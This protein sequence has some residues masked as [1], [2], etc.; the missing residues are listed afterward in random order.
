MKQCSKKEHTMKSRTPKQNVIVAPRTSALIK[1]ALDRLDMNPRELSLKMGNAY[2]HIRLLAKGEKFGSPLM[3][4]EIARILGIDEKALM[5]AYRE[6]KADKAGYKITT[7]DPQLT[8]L[9]SIFNRLPDTT[10]SQLVTYAQFVEKNNPDTGMA[11]GAS[12]QQ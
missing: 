4:R 8:V 10:K 6:D 3:T 9:I 7:L 11:N 12:A 2:D 1:A 5:T